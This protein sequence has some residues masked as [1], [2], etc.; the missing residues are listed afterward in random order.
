MTRV[1][2]LYGTT[3]GHT[4]QVAYSISETLALGGVETDVIQAGTIDPQLR[5]YSGTIVA[6]SVHAGRYQ[7]DVEHW[8]RA[9]AAELKAQPTAFV[10]VC[11]AVLA[12]SNP[13]TTADL[14]AIVTRFL[15]T[16]GWRPTVIKHVAGAL[17][18][19]RY[20]IFKRWMMKRIVARS[21]GATDTSKDYDYTDW[22]DLRA[23]AN[24]FR[25]RIPAAA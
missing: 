22:A 18:Y 1:L 9:H 6:A 15:A 2:I 17:L 13:K 24:E 16:T 20:G 25:R 14:D 21:G 8:V 23:F 11:L 5:N 7:K 4:R 10:S 12:K 19:T 3:D